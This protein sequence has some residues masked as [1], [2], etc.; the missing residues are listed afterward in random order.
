[1]DGLVTLRVGAQ[2]PPINLGSAFGI[3]GI[4]VD[5]H[6]GRLVRRWRWTT[7]D[8][9]KVE[10]AVGE[11]IERKGVDLAQPPVIFHGRQ[12]CH[13]RR[14]ACGGPRNAGC[15]SLGLAPRTAARGGALVQGPEAD[16]LLALAGL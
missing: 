9:V 6:F 4:T 1:M 11:L 14:P 15:P 16:H 2:N 10:Q 5:T 13:A 3:P 7:E 8:P 12:V